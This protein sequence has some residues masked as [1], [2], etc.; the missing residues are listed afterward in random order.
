MSYCDVRVQFDEAFLL[1]DVVSKLV[2]RSLIQEL[3]FVLWFHFPASLQNGKVG[4]VG[5]YHGH[6]TQGHLQQQISHV[7]S[8]LLTWQ[9]A[10]KSSDDEAIRIVVILVDL[11]LDHITRLHTK[12]SL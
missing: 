8:H 5:Y 3:F 12:I 9:L 7:V 1:W 6:T 10:D 2:F 4:L 11:Q